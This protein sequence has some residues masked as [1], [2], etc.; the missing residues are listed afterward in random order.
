MGEELQ[1]KRMPHKSALLLGLVGTALFLGLLLAAAPADYLRDVKPILEKNCYA[2]HGSQVQMQDLRLDSAEAILKGGSRGP[3]VVPGK[4]AESR[5]IKAVTGAEGFVR[6]PFE[7]PPLVREEIELLRTWIDQGAKTAAAEQPR[8]SEKVPEPKPKATNHWA[9]QPPQRP[10][11]PKVRN[12]AWARNPSDGFVL[13]RLEREGLRPSPEADRAT[14]LR[15][16]SLDLTGL[17][18]TPAELDAFLADRSPDAY[19][20]QVDRLLA[21]PRYG[22]RMAMQWMDLA[23][24]ADTHGYHIDSHRDMWHWRDWVIN[25][26]NRNLPFDRFTIEQ[27]AGDLLPNATVEQRIATG[28]NRNHMI[29]FEGGAIPEEYLAEYVVDRVETTSVVWMGMTMGCARCHDHKYE[30][31]TQKEFYRFFAFFHNVAEKGLDGRTGNAE[32]VVKLPSPEQKS[33]LERLTCAIEDKERALPEKAVAALQEQWEKTRLE[34]LPE[35][36]RNGLLAHY[37]LD[38]SLADTSGNYRHARIVRGEVTYS[39]GQVFRSVDF[40]GET[41]VELGPVAAFERTDPFTLALWLRTGAPREMAVLQKLAGSDGRRGLELAFDHSINVGDLKRGAYLYFRLIHR[42]P[43]QAIEIRTKGRLLQS[44]WHHVAFAYDGSGKA[45]GLTLFLN[46]KREPFEVL[47]DNLAGSVQNLSPLEVG[48]KNNGLPYKGQLDDV[49]IYKRPLDPAEVETLALHLPI[50][51]I[52][53]EAAGKRSKDQRDKLREYFLTYDAPEHH[54]QTYAALKSLKAQKERLDK[55]IPS[56]MVMEELKKPRD[57]FVLIRGDYRAKGEK[58]EPDVPSVLPPLPKDAPRNRLG[59][60]R[61]LV[62]PAHPLT[63]RVAVNH[64]WQ[65]YFGAGLVKIAE[66][67]GTRGEPPSHPALLDWLATEFIR[68]GWDVKAMQRLILTSAT[69]RQ[70]SGSTPELR[71]KDPENRLLARGP[72]F[73]LPAE[74]VRDNAL[75]ASGVLNEKLGGPDV[76]PYQPKGLWEE[77]AYGDVYSAQSYT[78]GHGQDLYRRSMYAF[79]KRTSPPPT[80][81]IFDAPDREKCTARRPR[82]NTPL[83]ALALMN[84]PTFV[85]AARALA[86]RAMTEGGKDTARRIRYAFRLATA[87]YPSPAE[88]QVLAELARRQLAHYRRDK[89]AARKLLAVGESRFDQKLDAGELAAWTTVASTILNMDETITKE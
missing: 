36:P 11:V 27:L 60:A 70:S 83:Q 85:E 87:R 81:A 86:Q 51:A 34:T 43:E 46:G 76:F 41:H 6:M 45:S 8:A 28:F 38:G 2:C 14:L 7:K 25:A 72:R 73:R 26:F 68:T 89:E 57:T 1:L 12:Q 74:T 88:Q 77:I 55:A 37:E 54:R 19:E 64:F 69:Y 71:A 56:S 61:W 75:Y 22:E 42:W 13:A 82:T 31:V 79:W 20:K 30:P 48:N 3:V 4:S 59:L 5:L 17:P 66:D 23:R 52:L 21:S 10:D 15:R 65:L 47:R 33:E 32:P 39:S 18:P 29:N 78:P 58:V 63:A 80:L 40:S 53:S 62:D 84:D 35:P 50:R 67:F 49:R 44:T 16:L 24:Y 9:Y